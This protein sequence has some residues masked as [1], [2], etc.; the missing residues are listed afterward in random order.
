MSLFYGKTFQNLYTQKRYFNQTFLLPPQQYIEFLKG[1][2]KKFYSMKGPKTLVEFKRLALEEAKK[3]CTSMKLKSKNRNS[4]KEDDEEGKRK[5]LSKED[6]LNILE[7]LYRVIDN[8]MT[9]LNQN[10]RNER[11]KKYK[12][13]EEYLK[14]IQDYEYKKAKFIHFC[15]Q[16]I[17]K[18]NGIKYSLLKASIFYF[19]SQNDEEVVSK[20]NSFTKIGKLFALA[21]KRLDVEEIVEVLETYYENLNYMVTN[22]TPGRNDYS[23]YALTLLN[24]LIYE[25]FGKEEEQI[26]K[27]IEEN[28]LQ[29]TNTQVNKLLERIQNIIKENILILFDI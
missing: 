18:R 20:V 6:V 15:I 4:F 26:F 1:V 10:C 3:V 11:R 22:A 27:Y 14:I 25:N 21:P 9:T 2:Y 28:N 12:I 16:E 17:C 13:E 7:A 8:P 19:I 29:E 5:L 24:D 23:K